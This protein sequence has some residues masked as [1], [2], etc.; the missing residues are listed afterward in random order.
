MIRY[1]YCD[2]S[3]PPNDALSCDRVGAVLLVEHAVDLG[4]VAAGKLDHSG[5]PLL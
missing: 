3:L 2:E 4:N 5:T 1:S